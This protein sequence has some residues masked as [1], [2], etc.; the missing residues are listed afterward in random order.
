MYPNKDSTRQLQEG[1]RSCLSIPYNSFTRTCL[2]YAGL[3]DAPC[4]ETRVEPP[5]IEPTPSS[6]PHSMPSS[7]PF[8]ETQT[9]HHSMPSSSAH[10]SSEPTHNI[11]LNSPF[12]LHTPNDVVRSS[13]VAGV[14]NEEVGDFSENEDD[15]FTQHAINDDEDKDMCFFLPSHTLL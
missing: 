14:H 1:G 10:R 3:V 12:H 5:Y 15:I 4:D 2:V 9:N 13:V 7:Y 11:D 6:Y 8:I